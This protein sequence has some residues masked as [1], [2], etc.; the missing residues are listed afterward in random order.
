MQQHRLAALLIDPLLLVQVPGWV[1]LAG[2][3]LQLRVV[4]H[5]TDLPRTACQ[6]GLY[7]DQLLHLPDL[8]KNWLDLQ[9]QYSIK[10]CF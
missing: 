4:L 7:Q 9:L 8:S 10:I 3:E 2:S 5:R 1:S 6:N